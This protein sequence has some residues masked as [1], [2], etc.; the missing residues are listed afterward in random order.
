MAT[1]D[2]SQSELERMAAIEHLFSILDGD[3]TADALDSARAWLRRMY[4]DDYAIV[5]R[6]LRSVRKLADVDEF[7]EMLDA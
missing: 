4:G 1:M 7:P 6:A 5:S 2:A 3:N